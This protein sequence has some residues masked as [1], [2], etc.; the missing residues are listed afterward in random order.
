MVG[1]PY[2]WIKTGKY[3]DLS[4]DTRKKHVTFIVLGFGLPCLILGILQVLQGTNDLSY[5]RWPDP[6]GILAKLT[7]GIA[8]LWAL[9]WVFFMRGAEI[10]SQIQ[11]ITSKSN[12]FYNKPLYIKIISI[13]ISLSV[14]STVFT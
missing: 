2:W 11:M 3:P 7:L 10:L 9:I 8:A 6:Y 14:L 13:F 5:T 4:V 12:A 1:A